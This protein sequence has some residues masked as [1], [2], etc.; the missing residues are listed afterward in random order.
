MK[1]V[2]VARTETQLLSWPGSDAHAK[3]PTRTE[4]SSAGACAA[5]AAKSATAADAT[6]PRVFRARYSSPAVGAAERQTVL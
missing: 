5:G 6:A 3:P 4:G 1:E 2:E